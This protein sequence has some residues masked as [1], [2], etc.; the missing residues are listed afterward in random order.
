MMSTHAE[1]RMLQHGKR[2]QS[3]VEL[4]IS[5]TVM[6]LLLSGA[7]SFGMA[8]FS[9][10]SIRDAAQE[11]ALYGSFHPCVDANLN[12]LCESTEVVNQPGIEERVRAASTGP[13]DLAAL[14]AGYITAEAVTGNTCEGSTGGTP[15]AVKVTVQYDYPIFMPFM[16]AILG[17]QTIHLTA[18]ATDTILE[19]RCAAGP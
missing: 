12:A 10:V 15:N 14:P 4:A 19:P 5:L 3:L 2:G 6:L 9:Y 8:Y 13:V 7:L 1:R 18:S 16:G 11:G 17:S